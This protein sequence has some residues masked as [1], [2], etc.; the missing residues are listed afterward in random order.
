LCALHQL[1][2]E[3][4]RDAVLITGVK[5]DIALLR[6][7]PPQ[8]DAHVTVLDIALA[9]NHDALNALL[10]A[11]ACVEYFDHHHPG[12]I[13]QHGNL[14]TH[15]VV[16]ADVCTSVLVDRHLGGAQRIWAVVGAF[17]D[18]MPGTAHGLASTLDLS[19]T[20]LQALQDLGECL[21]YNAYGDSEQ[22]LFL[23]P[24]QLYVQLRP[25][26]DPFQFIEQSSSLRSIRAGRMADL[27]Q[28][29]ACEPHVTCDG[30]VLYLLPD[31]H[32]SRRVRGAFGN[33]LA[34][35]APDRAHAVLTPDGRGCYVVS[36]RAPVKA[37]AGAVELCLQ[38]P[39]GG[40]RAGAAGIDRLEQGQLAEFVRAFAQAYCQGHVY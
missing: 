29:S 15:I 8:R 12:A 38:F 19:P 1:R 33:H 7:V 5:R 3:V 27:A 40:G 10:A 30:G 9:R 37:L 39:T 14:R 21:N 28:A 26:R 17:G 22:D 34:H 31:A 35:A 36:V 18:N 2:L 23:A 16:G 25:H 4:P 6:Q 13:P 24:A 11:G 32:W 20:Q